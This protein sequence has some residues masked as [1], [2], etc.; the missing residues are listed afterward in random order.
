MCLG[1]R[2]TDKSQALIAQHSATNNKNH[3]KL[4]NSRRIRPTGVS[5]SIGVKWLAT[6]ASVGYRISSCSIVLP[7]PLDN[8]REARQTPRIMILRLSGAPC[9]LWVPVV[10]Q[11]S[12]DVH[13]RGCY[14]HKSWF[15]QSAVTE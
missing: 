3:V 2:D 5:D 4:K 1:D 8:V 7:V 6:V 15:T 13:T 10:H 9:S 14:L 11:G 12:R